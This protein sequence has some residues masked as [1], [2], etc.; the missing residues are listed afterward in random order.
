MSRWL[1]AWLR[2]STPSDQRRLVEAIIDQA[3]ASASSLPP[4][5]C[6]TAIWEA[7]AGA[8]AATGLPTP[9]QGVD[10]GPPVCGTDGSDEQDMCS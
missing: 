10:K 7:L 2:H 1:A 3:G 4:R 8:V 5:V 6:L 9:S